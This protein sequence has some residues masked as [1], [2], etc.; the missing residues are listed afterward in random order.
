[1]L[2]QESYR[3]VQICNTGFKLLSLLGQVGEAI[4]HPLYL[5]IV[6]F[7]TL[8]LLIHFGE[9]LVDSL[10]GCVVTVVEKLHLLRQNVLLVLRTRHQL[11]RI[12]CLW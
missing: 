4:L 8:S 3:C 12:L 2:Q 9:D 5:N 6:A 10:G 1:M 11:L 7:R